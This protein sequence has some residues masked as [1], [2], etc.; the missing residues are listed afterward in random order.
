M[1]IINIIILFCVI[2]NVIKF[3]QLDRLLVLQSLLKD[4]YINI[5]NIFNRIKEL[6]LL[7]IIYKTI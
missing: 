4:F 2:V 6:F 5:V 7:Y 3:I 1:I